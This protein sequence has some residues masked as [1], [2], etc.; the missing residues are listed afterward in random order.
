[1]ASYE[2][3]GEERAGDYRV[4]QGLPRKRGH[5]APEGLTQGSQALWWG[6]TQPPE[7]CVHLA[8]VFLYLIFATSSVMRF[9]L[10]MGRVS[11]IPE[12]L[13]KATQPGSV[14]RCGG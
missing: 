9:L 8:L 3:D 5:L 13:P 6:S 4:G 7:E 1:M 2:V 10:D 14:G 12:R 11:Q